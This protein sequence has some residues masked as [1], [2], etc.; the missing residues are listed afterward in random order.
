M[1]GVWITL[2]LAGTGATAWDFAPA[3]L[4]C[5]LGAGM[6]F[7]PLFDIILG[8][9]ADEAA[10]SASGV[11]TAVQQFGG[12]IG[13]A[14]IGTMFFELLPGQE[15]LGSMKATTLAAAGLFVLCLAVTLLLPKK[16]RE[17]ASAH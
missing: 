14:V 13:V 9:V 6:V 10:G 12:A 15:F 11:L 2:E 7:A 4:V 3:T 17:G 8:D 16:A 1:V 5:G